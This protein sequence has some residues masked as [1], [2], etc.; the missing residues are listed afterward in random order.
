MFQ[1]TASDRPFMTVF[2]LLA[3]LLAPVTRMIQDRRD[4]RLAAGPIT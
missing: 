4:E 3:G 2:F 1:A